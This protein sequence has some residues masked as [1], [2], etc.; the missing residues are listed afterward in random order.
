MSKQ[1]KTW[2]KAKKAKFVK[3]A[4]QPREADRFIQGNWL[5]DNDT[6]EGMHRGCFFGCMMQS[7][8]SVLETATKEMGLPAWIVHVAERIFEGLP[9]AEAKEFPVQLLEAIATTTDTEQVWKDWNYT[10]LMD[11]EH[12]QYKYCGDN[13]QCQ[14][15]VKQCADL[16]KMDNITYSAAYS[17]D[18]AAYSAVDSA[19]YSARSVAYSADSADSAVDSAV[20]SAAYSNYQW[21]RDTLI[22][23]I[24]EKL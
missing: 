14:D 15:A 16:F 19:V 2:S 1:Y 18:S 5:Q 6:E 9:K 13:Q 23:L 21:M 17:A 4:K 3:I 8:D 22:R 20:D 10:I 12:G 11:E 24:R 7:E